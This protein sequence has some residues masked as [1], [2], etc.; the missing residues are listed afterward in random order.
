ML[1]GRF[2]ACLYALM[3]VFFSVGILSSYT[4]RPTHESQFF[5]RGLSFSPIYKD[6]T[7][8]KSFFPVIYELQINKPSTDEEITSATFMERFFPGPIST[9]RRELRSDQRVPFIS[10][11][12]VARYP[13]VDFMP[14]IIGGTIGHIFELRPATI[15][16]LT[17]ALCLMQAL[18]LGIIVLLV[19]PA[20]HLPVLIGL[21]SPVTLMIGFQQYA[22]SMV[23]L[24]SF[25]YLALILRFIDRDTPMKW[26]H[27]LLLAAC[28]C[29]LSVSKL[30]YC[31]LTATVFLIPASQ[32]ASH[33]QRLLFVA[34]IPLLCISAS[35][36]CVVAA[37]QANYGMN[38]L[39]TDRSSVDAR[40][41][42]AVNMLFASPLEVAGKIINT[43]A[44]IG[45]WHDKWA[46]SFIWMVKAGKLWRPLGDYSKGFY[47]LILAIPFIPALLPKN[48]GAGGLIRLKNC[49]TAR[50]RLLIFGIVLLSAILIAIGLFIDWTNIRKPVISGIG[51]RYFIPFLPYLAL[52][53]HVCLPQ[54]Y[55]T[56]AILAQLAASI[57][58]IGIIYL[59]II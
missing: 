54:K 44:D 33:R 1:S 42:A 8:P 39:S 30:V 27:W 28:G 25:L 51:G 29:V 17:R 31:L 32:F 13:V 52:I 14:Q 34:G 2:Y 37:F 11:R 49:I 24:S 47:C 12:N 3:L 36:L 15:F 21:L 4:L 57:L 16:Y 53:T 7:L 48:H 22:D 50:G 19:L 9:K 18:V 10:P 6:G 43:Y 55:Y 45:F 58:V 20:F 35:V 23:T 38:I 46:S 26:R 5:L 59:S 41:L 40:R 56:K